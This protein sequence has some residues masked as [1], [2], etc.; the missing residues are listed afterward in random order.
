MNT[1]ANA[2]VFTGDT[3]LRTCT[4]L[5]TC[6]H[7]HTR[8]Q[9]R[10]SVLLYEPYANESSQICPFLAAR[11]QYESV[12]IQHRR[13][14]SHSYSHE[15]V[16]FFVLLGFIFF[17]FT[18]SFRFFEFNCTR[19]RAAVDNG[20]LR[21]SPLYYDRGHQIAHRS[22]PTRSQLYLIGDAAS[23]VRY[24]IPLNGR[25]PLNGHPPSIY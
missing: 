20:A 3:Y 15:S 25:R 7:I 19:L 18:A 2:L 12:H 16:I 5:F 14:S 4:Y 22:R 24:F 13:L 10:S 6:H 17:K 23:R 1:P 9:A 11:P 21:L 8:V